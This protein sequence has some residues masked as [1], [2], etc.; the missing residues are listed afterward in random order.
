MYGIE[1]A[2]RASITANVA[3]LPVIDRTSDD[4]A[5][6]AVDQ[7]VPR[8]SPRPPR[9]SHLAGRPASDRRPAQRVRLQ[10]EAY[11]PGAP[12]WLSAPDLGKWRPAVPEW[13]PWL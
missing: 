8:W 9:D 1:Q 5:S 6:Q 4:A 13:V 2:S 10:Q 7:E 12:A 3:S 11:S